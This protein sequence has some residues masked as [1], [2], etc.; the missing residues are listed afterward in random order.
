MMMTL[1]ILHNSVIVEVFV[2]KVEI[3]RLTDSRPQ[4][5]DF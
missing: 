1:F 5:V 4:V 2:V 3:F